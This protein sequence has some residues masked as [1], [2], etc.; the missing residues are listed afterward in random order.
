M[1]HPSW[2]APQAWLGFIELDKAIVPIKNS[3]TKIS[4]VAMEKPNHMHI[5]GENIKWHS[6]AGINLAVC[7]KT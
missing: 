1:T 7:Y 4:R 2:V 6:H 5:A 3:G